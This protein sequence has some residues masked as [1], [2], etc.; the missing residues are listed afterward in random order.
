MLQAAGSAHVL[1]IH[2]SSKHWDRNS[3]AE[4]CGGPQLLGR[5]KLLMKWLHKPAGGGMLLPMGA[6]AQTVVCRQASHGVL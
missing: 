1:G 3:W 5:I 2:W 6:I 4:T